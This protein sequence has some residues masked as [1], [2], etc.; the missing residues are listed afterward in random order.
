MLE[1]RNGLSGSVSK[2][3]EARCLASYSLT[4]WTLYVQGDR[5]TGTKAGPAESP[6]KISG[7]AVG[8]GSVGEHGDAEA[9]HHGYQQEIKVFEYDP[10]F[11][12]R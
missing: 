8:P 5:S 1:S 11:A 6:P 10:S 4:S 2:G 7:P 9:R 3:P 12:L